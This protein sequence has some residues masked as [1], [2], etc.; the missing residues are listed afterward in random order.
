MK[1]KNFVELLVQMSARVKAIEAVLIHK[2]IIS[3]EELVT[4][5]L[6]SLAEIQSKILEE[7]PPKEVKNEG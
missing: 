1:Q 6:C 2:K 7:I 3:E 5:Q 4:A